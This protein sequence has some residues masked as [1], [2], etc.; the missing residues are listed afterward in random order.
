[1]TTSLN[2]RTDTPGHTQLIPSMSAPDGARLHK[3]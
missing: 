1:M 2:T 3:E